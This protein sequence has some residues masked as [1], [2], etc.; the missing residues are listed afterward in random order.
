[1]GRAIVLLLSAALAGCQPLAKPVEAMS[2]SELNALADQI[3]ARCAAQGAGKGTPRYRECF[4][5]EA[6][7]ERYN[8]NARRAAAQQAIQNWQA[9]RPRT[10]NCTTTFGQTNCTTY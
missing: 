5:I 8:R 2:Y 7:A 3:D 9:T 4:Q 10:T 1:M 6:N